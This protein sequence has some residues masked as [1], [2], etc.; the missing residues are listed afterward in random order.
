MKIV[1]TG[2]TGFIGRNLLNHLCPRHEVFVLARR[3]SV[4]PSPARAC[5]IEQDLARAVE[6]S[7]L[8]SPIDAV[9][10][11]A[12]SSLYKQ[13]PDKAEDIFQINVESTFRLLEYAR[14]ASAKSFLFAS[15]GGVYGQSYEK[16]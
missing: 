2:G 9:I 15:T 7:R 10:H 11:L 16:C 12:Q 4:W 3:G 1:L 14:R 6:V 13:F 5:W 8:P